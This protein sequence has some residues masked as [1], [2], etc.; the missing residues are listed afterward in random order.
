MESGDSLYRS[1]KYVKFG[2]LCT[3]GEPLPYIWTT[4]WTC[5]LIFSIISV[6]TS[7]YKHRLH[8]VH[9]IRNLRNRSWCAILFRLINHPGKWEA[10]KCNQLVSNVCWGC[11]DEQSMRKTRLLSIQ[12]EVER[13]TSGFLQMMRQDCLN[14]VYNM[15]FWSLFILFGKFY[16]KFIFAKQLFHDHM[17][18]FY[19]DVTKRFILTKL[20]P[21]GK[22][23]KVNIYQVKSFHT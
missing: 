23:Q 12:N 3:Y 8:I 20:C 17:L 11:L 16:Q 9:Y 21:H 10:W 4:D 19:Q 22:F 6:C 1:S 13:S 14:F 15:N 2:Q 7:K 18:S 5:P